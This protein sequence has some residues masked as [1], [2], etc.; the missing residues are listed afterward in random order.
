MRDT[1]ITLT[2]T[3]EITYPVSGGL[4]VTKAVTVC[5]PG[6]QDR[7]IYRR[8]SGFVTEAQKQM[9]LAADSA[10]VD[11]AAHEMDA[12]AEEAAEAAAA[13]PAADIDKTEDDAE[14]LMAIGAFTMGMGMDADR[15]AQVKTYVE[16]VLSGNTRLAYIADSTVPG[17]RIPVTEAVWMSLAGSNGVAAID[18]LVLA[19]LSFFLKLRPTASAT[20]SGTMPSLP[21]PTPAPASSRTRRH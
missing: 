10:R 11:K 7:D 19:F 17:G 15:Q 6:F 16:R 8:M 9:A 14:R 21:S 20:W 18:T 5:E 4:G 3:N 2:F 1:E 13:K 12:A